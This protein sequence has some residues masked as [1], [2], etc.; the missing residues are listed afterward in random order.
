M[1]DA[2]S[3]AGRTDTK[4]HE[5]ASFRARLLAREAQRPQSTLAIDS[6]VVYRPGST[7]SEQARRAAEAV[8]DEIRRRRAEAEAA[9]AAA[10]AAAPVAEAEEPVVVPAAAPVIAA[11]AVQA[12]LPVQAPPSDA[13]LISVIEEVAARKAEERAREEELR[14]APPVPVPV[15]VPVAAERREA[16]LE[17]RP[18]VAEA[19]EHVD[20]ATRIG[21]MSQIAFAGLAVLGLAGLSVMAAENALQ[22]PDRSTG[23]RTGTD[24]A[25][26]P[27]PELKAGGAS[28]VALAAAV[29]EEPRAWFNYQGVADMLA[30]KKAEMDAAALVAQEAAEREARLQAANAIAEAEAARV[31]EEQEAAAKA[32]EDARLAEAAER[33]RL[34][35]AEAARVAEAEAQR[36]A[37]L[38]AERQAAAEAEAQRLAELEAKKKAEAEAET[39]RLAELETQ[40]LAKLEAERKAAEDAA[41]KEA[42]E[43]AKAEEA[44]KL[45]LAALKAQAEADAAEALRLE[46]A[47]AKAK[48]DRIAAE[49]ALAVQT[50]AAAAAPKPE[51]IVFAP[52]SGPVPTA[53]S[54]KPA[55]PKILAS[56]PAP[57]APVTRGAPKSLLATSASVR[58]FDAASPQT[59]EAFLASRV[60]RA[61]GKAMKAGDAA[62]VQQVFRTILDNG[63]DGTTQTIATPDGRTVSVLLERTIS[64]E[65]GQSTV[66]TVSYTPA[67][68][69]V[70]RVV[71]EP[72]PVT[73][74]VMCRDV[75]YEFGGQERG[76]FAA[77]QAPD[78]SWTLARATDVVRVTEAS[79]PK[80]AG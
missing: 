32:A 31:A 46:Q 73:V 38:E 54:Y 29:P 80:S 64:R 62:A 53:A 61:S 4:A 39:K 79:L 60:Q 78:G 42:F 52:Y 6:G 51:A 67:V 26:E 69:A 48:A 34:A 21:D 75:A 5:H 55:K 10:V 77:C 44:E 15:V 47:A 13:E 30:E 71:T 65:M 36:Q 28:S 18:Q 20:I 3:T 41:R 68:N 1:F 9:Q 50:A 70:T 12:E 74:R 35:E 24:S 76:R 7:T 63:A 43:R 58:E 2:H 49:K 14:R 25:S 11:E 27:A 45:R 33:Q 16:A 37:Q 17:Q 57:E 22:G 19:E 72:A 8:R 66:R 56:A 23:V 40:R 59:P